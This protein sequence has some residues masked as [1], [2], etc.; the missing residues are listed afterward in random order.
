MTADDLIEAI[1]ADYGVAETPGPASKAA[2]EQYGDQQ[3]IV[4]RWQDS[5]YS[6]DLIRSAY[7][8]SFRLIGAVK[9]LQAR[10][11]ASLGEAKRLDDREAPQMESDRAALQVETERAR[12]EKARLVNKPNFRP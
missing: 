5:Q 9:N 11:Q 10:A 8:P 2:G 3:E 6:F 1:S 7:G 4:A 12:L